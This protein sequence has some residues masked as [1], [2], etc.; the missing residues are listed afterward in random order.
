VT[1]GVVCLSSERVDVMA[2]DG[3][4]VVLVRPETSPED[5]PG[6][7]VASGLLTSTGGLV[8]HAAVV[9]RELDLPT[10]VGVADLVLDEPART[11]RL[12]SALV[13]EGDEIT[14]DGAAGT[15]HLGVAPVRDPAGDR[16]VARF[17]A[18]RDRRTSS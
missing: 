12:G 1:T 15:V 2:T 6:M 14:I 7:I 4:P 10:V 13:A 18:W 11:A 16:R 17:R 9:A 3:R 8:S 5:L